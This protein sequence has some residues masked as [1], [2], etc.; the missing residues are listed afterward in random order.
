MITEASTSRFAD[1]P[2]A[3][4][5]YNE[6]GSG[7]AV[8]MLHGG[9]PGASGWS[10]FAGNAGAFAE[11]YRVLMV[12]MPGF[13]KSDK[14]YYDEGQGTFTARCILELMDHL[15]IQK[16]HF[17][18]NSLGAHVVMC[19]ALSHPDRVGDLILMAPA[20]SVGFVM[21][22]PTEGAKVLRSYYHG[23]E[24]SVEKMRNFISKLVYDSSKISDEVVRQRYEASVVPEVVQWARTMG[25]RPGRI[26][27]IWNRFSEIKQ[28]TLLV[29]GR[30]DAVV[31]LDRALF[32]VQ[33]MPNVRL[34]VFG[35]CGHWVMVERADEF[36]RLCRDFLDHP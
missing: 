6:V 25:P 26:E 15:S 32:M 9:G 12:D 23:A 28:R 30:D 17:V 19:L 3:R 20:L 33:Q 31:P 34:H 14:P 2:T 10:N 21:P 4:L 35:H 7:E 18:G 27:P 29:W 36:N 16:A 11:R 22:W 1:L 5:H 13:G 8:I 24:P